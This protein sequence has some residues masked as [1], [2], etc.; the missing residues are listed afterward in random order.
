LQ[1]R[2][3]M[4]R[5][6]PARVPAALAAAALAAALAIGVKWT[7]PA[8]AA[9][10]TVRLAAREFLYL[11]KTLSAPPGNAV[12]VV[13]NEGAIEHNFVIESEA[14]AKVAEIP[15]LEPG[16]TL[17]VRA[18]LLPGT[19]AIYCSLPG[20]REAGMEAVLHVP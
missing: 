3:V 4:P 20:H 17:E 2:A 5:R 14:K 7:P 11:P 18:A 6:P 19:Y 1:N 9:A 8:R 16:Q 10:A 12:F 15:I 13:T